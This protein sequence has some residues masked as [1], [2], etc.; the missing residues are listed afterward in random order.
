MAWLRAASAASATTSVMCAQSL[1]EETLLERLAPDLADMAF[2][3]GPLILQQEAVMGQ[4]HLPWPRQLAAA[5]HA[6][7]GDGVVGGAEGVGGDD[8]GAIA[9]EASDAM[10]PGGLPRCRPA[11]RRQEGTKP[12]RQHRLPGPRRAEE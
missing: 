5:D 9:G 3:L 8:G 7:S 12:P 4:G 6:D 10:D 11:H 1:V 2:G